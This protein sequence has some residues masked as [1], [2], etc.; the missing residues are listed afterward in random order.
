MPRPW[1]RSHVNPNKAFDQ[2]VEAGDLRATKAQL[3]LHPALLNEREGLWMAAA[4]GHAELVKFFL[5]Q[6]ADPDARQAQRDMGFGTPLLQ[7]AMS[8]H[9]EVAQ[10][11]ID[12]GATVDILTHTAMGH[13]DEVG[14]MLADDPDLVNWEFGTGH[15]TI[16][17][18]PISLAQC[19]GTDAMYRLLVEYGAK[20]DVVNVWSAIQAENH[21]AIEYLFELLP[22]R[23]D[24]STGPP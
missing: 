22:W 14:R 4:N 5:G 16:E 10:L 7:A 23:D 24:P 13:L 11:L 6:G 9:Q 2:A 3:D 1:S 20:P 12:G 19:C 18:R 15:P 8:G 21:A 17:I